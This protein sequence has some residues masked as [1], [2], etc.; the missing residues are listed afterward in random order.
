MTCVDDVGRLHISHLLLLCRLQLLHGLVV[1]VVDLLLQL[2][3]MVLHRLD[4][5]RPALLVLVQLLR[6]QTQTQR[7]KARG[8]TKYTVI[9]TETKSLF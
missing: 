5:L 3:T 2:L 8:I 7:D 6:T 9:N 1:P 4:L